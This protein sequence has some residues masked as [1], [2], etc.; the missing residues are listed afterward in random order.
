MKTF[1]GRYAG[2]NDILKFW[3]LGK[4]IKVSCSGDDIAEGDSK[5]LTIESECQEKENEIKETDTTNQ[6]ILEDGASESNDID[7]GIQK[8]NPVEEIESEMEKHEETE[9]SKIK[10]PPKMLKRGKAKGAELTVIGLPSS[11]KS[12][13][14][15]IKPSI[16]PFIKLKGIEKDRIILECVVSPSVARNALKGVLLIGAEEI[17]I[18]INEISDLIRDDNYVDFNRIEKYFTEET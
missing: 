14:N 11:K 7:Q 8:Q 16:T 18:N 3:K 13:R 9:L 6:K 5:N 17:K 2:L 1:T 15:D 4:N 12:K 10:M